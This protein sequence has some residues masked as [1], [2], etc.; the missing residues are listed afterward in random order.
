MLSDKDID[1]STRIF[2]NGI[3]FRW[4]TILV[5]RIVELY[6]LEEDQA[7][8]VRELFLKPNNWAMIVAPALSP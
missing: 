2:L 1:K 8:T 6:G 4:A 3:W 7:A 5:D